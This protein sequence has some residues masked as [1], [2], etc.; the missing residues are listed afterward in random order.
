MKNYPEKGVYLLEIKLTRSAEIIIGALGEKTFP[1]GYYFY[2]GTAQRTLPARLKRH[3][4]KNKKFH[5]HIDYLLAVA[6]LEADLVFT[7]PKTGECLL[8]NQLIKIG[9]KVIINGFGASDC[10][11]DTHLIYFPLT[12][13]L[14]K[15]KAGLLENKKLSKQLSNKN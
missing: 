9:G 3:Y 11:C 12:S 5:W 4:S 7:L 1:A 8:S 13:D 15:I 6:D 10:N 2:A 14:T